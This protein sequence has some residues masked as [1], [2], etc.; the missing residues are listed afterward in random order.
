M[1]DLAAVLPVSD[2]S[3][4]GPKYDMDKILLD[5]DPESIV[6]HEKEN[7]E[8][9][10]EEEDKKADSATEEEEEDAGEEEEPPKVP[11]ARPSIKDIKAAYPD[12]F[13]KFPDVKD[14][15]FREA[16]F[17]QFFPTVEDAKESFED[18]EAFIALSDA[19]LAGNSAPMLQSLHKTDP[20]ALTA[21]AASFLPNLYK[22]DSATYSIAVTPLFENLVRQA[23]KSGDENMKNSALNIAQYLF[24]DD[25]EDI[26]N[27]KK[28][29][30]KIPQI[31]EDQDKANKEKIAQQTTAFRT[32]SGFVSDQVSKNMRA[33]VFKDFDPEKVFT[34]SVRDMLIDDVIKRIDR[35]LVLDKGHVTVMSARWKRARNNGYTDDD[36]S[37]LISTYLARAKSLIPS[38]TQQVRNA[39]LGKTIKAADDKRA[40]VAAAPREQGGAPPRNGRSAP[41]KDYSKMTDREILDS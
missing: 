24:G 14:A 22:Q 7:A 3:G 19:A 9:V 18:N 6:D 25:G 20:K 15:I 27:G 23:F 34:K 40:R 8:E 5:E 12:F 31:T 30:S 39:A 13:D 37:K 29:M 1:P 28:T 38:I 2:K 36:K 35:Q 26:V 41:T 17:T 10:D 16:K 21:F 33:L 11:F 4:D 32:T